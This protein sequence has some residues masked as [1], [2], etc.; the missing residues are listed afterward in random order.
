M[1]IF[2]SVR[3]R[4]NIGT[5]STYQ[6]VPRLF[7]SDTAVDISPT[8]FNFSFGFKDT[9]VFLLLFT[10]APWWSAPLL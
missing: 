6:T 8:F 10:M 3:E 4:H 2:S 7:G 9:I 5:K 1:E